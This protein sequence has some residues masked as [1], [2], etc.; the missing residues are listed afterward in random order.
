MNRR[1]FVS[2]SAKTLAATLLVARNR[3]GKSTPGLSQLPT[4][5]WRFTAVEMVELVRQQKISVAELIKAH[6]RRVQAVNP[7]VNAATA[8]LEESA[9]R[10]AHQFDQELAKG[11]KVTALGGVP[12]SIKDNIDLAGFATT[13]GVKAFRNNIAAADAPQVAA[14][15]RGRAIPLVRTN[16]P[17]FALRY[18][19]DSGLNGPTLNPWNADL[20][21]GGS[22]GG[23]AVAVATGMVPIGLG[24]DYGGSLRYPAQCTGVCSI[25]PSRGRIP[26]FSSSIPYNNVPYSVKMFAVQGPIARSIADLRLALHTMNTPDHRDPAWVST[27]ITGALSAQPRVGLILDP[28]NFGVDPSVKEAVEK[29]GKILERQGIAVEEIDSVAL[30]EPQR[31]WAQ[32]VTTD[33]RHVFWNVIN[34][35]ASRAAID[36]VE[37][38]LALYPPLSINQFVNGLARVNGIAAAWNTSFEYFDA[39]IGPVSSRQPFR[40]GSDLGGQ[41]QARQILESQALT[42]TANLLGLPSV[43][44]PVHNANGLPQSIQIMAARFAEEKCLRI[45]EMIETEVGACSPIDPKW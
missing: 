25:R 21:T 35:H 7:K 5:L 8:T 38:F 10:S 1:R 40:V 6:L 31:L 13:D 44:L 28:G 17:D 41:E 29:A 3:P 15:K 4:E 45:A 22:S 36:F 43:S 32:I 18:H 14:F 30:R 11:K 16:M 9:L 19:T 12:F 23:D 24:N 39:V 42:V 34:Q 2:N 33:I 27:P 20:T 26:Y 37:A